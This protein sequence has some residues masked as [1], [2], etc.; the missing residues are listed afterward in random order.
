[1]KSNEVRKNTAFFLEAGGKE[2][3]IC[4]S[5]PESS[6]ERRKRREIERRETEKREKEEREIRKKKRDK[7]NKRKEKNK[8]NKE[9]IKQCGR[10]ANRIPKKRRQNGIELTK[11]EERKKEN[12]EEER[13]N[14]IKRKKER[15]REKGKKRGRDKKGFDL[16]NQGLRFTPGR[17]KPYYRK[18]IPT[19]FATF[20]NKMQFHLF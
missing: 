20:R 6:Y 5:L 7:R 2:S 18:I 15:G 13:G 11:R 1:M 4:G 16:K 10:N 9:T 17:K 12:K 8:R 14:K 3:F 19:S